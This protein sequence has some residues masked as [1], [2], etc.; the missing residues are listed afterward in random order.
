MELV[1]LDGDR[2]REIDRFGS[3]GFRLAP[4]CR[5][6]G[7]QLSIVHLAAGG[8]IG[9][10]PAVVR[11]VLAVAAGTATVSGGDGVAHEIGPGLAAVWEAG[12]EH[13][14]RTGEGLT[15]FVVEGAV[16]D[17]LATT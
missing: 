1:R 5:G 15:A 4:L 12:E 17:V 7:V 13:E 9:R 8:R 11:Q 14:T 16:L 2:G 10:H 3:V 6:E